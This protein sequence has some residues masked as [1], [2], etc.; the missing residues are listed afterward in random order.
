[1]QSILSSPKLRHPSNHVPGVFAA[2]QVALMVVVVVHSNNNNSRGSCNDVDDCM[3]AIVVVVV[4]FSFN[5]I[6]LWGNNT[7]LILFVMMKVCF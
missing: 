1:L 6:P 7:T 2:G 5:T 4:L 3:F